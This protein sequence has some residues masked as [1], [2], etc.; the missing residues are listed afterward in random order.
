M[1]VVNTVYHVESSRVALLLV[2][3]HQ[4]NIKGKSPLQGNLRYGAYD[5]G[6]CYGTM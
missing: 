1:V 5:L 3:T 2:Y 4:V 6:G